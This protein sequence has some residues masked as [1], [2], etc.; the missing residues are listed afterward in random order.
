MRFFIDTILFSYAQIFFSHRRWFGAVIMISTFVFPQLGMMALLGVI[1]SNL[2]AY[3]L[4]F[5]NEKIRSGFY[6]FN[7]ILFG[8]ASVY[9]YDL[10]FFLLYIIPVFIVLT[11]FISAFLEH[12]MA[13]SF[14]LPGLSLPFIWCNEM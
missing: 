8:A 14:N 2:I 12:Y 5:D 3:L 1:L 13:E 7:G 10:N 11:F 9:Y 4:K 6:G